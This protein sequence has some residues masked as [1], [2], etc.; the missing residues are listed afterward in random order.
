MN[1]LRIGQDQLGAG[2]FFERDVNNGKPLR[3]S[4]LRSRQTDALGLIHG[5][6]HVLNQLLELVSELPDRLSKFFKYRISKLYDGVD[7]VV[8]GDLLT[9]KISSQ[10]R[11]SCFQF[12][13]LTRNL[14]LDT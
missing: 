11:V 13:Q 1:D 5:L 2:I 6:K 9:G 4:D 10:F 14:K 7:H 3:N 12:Q 8:V